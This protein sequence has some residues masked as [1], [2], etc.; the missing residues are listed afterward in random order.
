MQT[1]MKAYMH[2]FTHEHAYVNPFSHPPFAWYVESCAW[3][4]DR[5]A[6]AIESLAWA[7]DIDVWDVDGRG[8][9][10][11]RFGWRLPACLGC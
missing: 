11:A 1:C 6:L 5:G 10:V 2:V 9:A 8:W 7:V 3:D 4:V